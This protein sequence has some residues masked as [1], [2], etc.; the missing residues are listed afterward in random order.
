MDCLAQRRIGRCAAGLPKS[1]F[2]HYLRY[3]LKV[4][5]PAI[6]GVKKTVRRKKGKTRGWRPG[7]KPGGRLRC[8]QF[9]TALPFSTVFPIIPGDVFVSVA[10]T[11]VG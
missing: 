4:I 11:V 10:D 9:R 6:P 5:K 2:F 1:A 7:A 8:C 3:G